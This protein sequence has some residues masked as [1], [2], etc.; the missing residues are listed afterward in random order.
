[1]S[2][3]LLKKVQD[4]LISAPASNYVKFFS[5]DS[6]GGLLYYMNSSGVAT[7]VG[8][9]SYNS[10]IDTTYSNLYSLYSSNGFA[11]G[12]YYYINDFRSIYEQPDFYFDDKL[13]QK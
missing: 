7:P 5:N 9:G 1:M 4:N 11:T 6:D 8:A 13:L 10:V 12:S 2:H 3:I